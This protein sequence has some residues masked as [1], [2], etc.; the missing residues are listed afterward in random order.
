[1]KYRV[2]LRE[3]IGDYSQEEW[4]EDYDT[5]EEARNRIDTVNE[6]GRSMRD[7]DW[8]MQAKEQIDEIQGS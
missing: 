3:V 7:K 4:T 6:Y 1:M 8:Y 5:A 2:Y